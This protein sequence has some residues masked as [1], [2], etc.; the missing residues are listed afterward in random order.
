MYAVLN[1]F[2]SDSLTK[3][4]ERCIYSSDVIMCLFLVL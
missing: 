4:L 1:S 2:G 3:S